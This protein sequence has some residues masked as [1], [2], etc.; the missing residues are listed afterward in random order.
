MQPNLLSFFQD[1]LVF[2][3]SKLQKAK[4]SPFCYLWE[5]Y[6]KLVN[7][8]GILLNPSNFVNQS[9]ISSLIFFPEECVIVIIKVIIFI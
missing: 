5:I 3:S 1:V 6:Y 8:V 7:A 9:F 4:W 2:L